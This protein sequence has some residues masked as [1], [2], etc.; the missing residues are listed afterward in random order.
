MQSKLYAKAPCGDGVRLLGIL[1]TSALGSPRGVEPP[2]RKK[3]ETRCT[4]SSAGVSG[5]ELG[6]DLLETGPG[7]GVS[8][9]C[10][11]AG[12]AADDL[13]GGGGGG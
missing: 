2:G 5:V 4:G 9:N 1:T 11:G 8:P 10:C 13:G 7:P 3:H 6:E 12:G